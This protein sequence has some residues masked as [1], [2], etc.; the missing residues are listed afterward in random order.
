MGQNDSLVGLAL[1][2]HVAGPGL[3]PGSLDGLQE[4]RFLGAES[5]VVPEH[6]WVCPQKQRKQTDKQKRK[7]HK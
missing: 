2:L 7:A 3:V 5:V 6:H 1:A 4:R